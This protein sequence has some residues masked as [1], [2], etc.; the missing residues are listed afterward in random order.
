MNTIPFSAQY[1]ESAIFEA[2]TAATKKR[3]YMQALKEICARDGYQLINFRRWLHR[4]GVRSNA[5]AAV[6][7][8]KSPLKGYQQFV[9]NLPKEYIAL[10]DKFR[11][12]KDLSRTE[13]VKRAVMDYIQNRGKRL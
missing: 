9:V 8:V 7:R 5:T 2:M 3:G 6:N 12:A 10:M 4:N 13:I 11:G 1:S